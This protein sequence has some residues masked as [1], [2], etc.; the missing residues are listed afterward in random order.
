MKR[1]VGLLVVILLLTVGV[2]IAT[3][4]TPVI[5]APHQ[6]QEGEIVT[7]DHGRPIQIREG[8]LACT[9]GLTQAFLRASVVSLDVEDGSGPYLSVGPPASEYWTPVY[10]SGLDATGCVTRAKTLWQIDWGYTLDELPV[11]QYPVHFLWY[12]AHPILDGGDYDGDGAPD[13]GTV[14]M[15]MNFIID[16]Q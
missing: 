6:L 2:S 15:E 13:V 11:G 10:D 16:V 7:V 5:I 4:D 3:A 14:Y 8:W 9:R 12:T 1:K